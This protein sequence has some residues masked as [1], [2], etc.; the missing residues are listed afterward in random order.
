MS[1]VQMKGAQ[2]VPYIRTD[3]RFDSREGA[4]RWLSRWRKLSSVYS[5]PLANHR[6]DARSLAVGV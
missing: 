4:G 1:A 5:K 3:G 2:M 6:E